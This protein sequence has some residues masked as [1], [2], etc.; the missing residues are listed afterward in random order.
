MNPKSWRSSIY[1]VA[2]GYLVYLAYGMVKSLIDREATTMPLFLQILFI[3]LFGVA[4]IVLLIQTWK[5][6]KKDRED[7]DKDPV[8]L[9]GK[10][11]SESEEEN[12]PEK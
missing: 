4:G 11:E 3:V 10:E 9:E 6:W 2:G 7:P 12:T 5:M 8:E 1:A